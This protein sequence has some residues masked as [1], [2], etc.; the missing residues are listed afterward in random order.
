MVPE[1]P[2]RFAE[3][4]LKS[5]GALNTDQSLQLLVHAVADNLLL[6]LIS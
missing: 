4:A 2:N 5:P 6:V 3:I 1:S